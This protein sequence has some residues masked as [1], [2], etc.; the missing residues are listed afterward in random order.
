M[1]HDTTLVLARIV[2]PVFVLA[3]IM[4]ITQPDRM[5]T[6]LGGYL[7]NDSLLL[8]SAFMSLILG[9]CVITFHPR[10]DTVSGIFISL[11]GIVLAARGAVLILAPQLVHEAAMYITTQPHVFPIAGCAAALLGVWL[12]YVGYISGTLRV[13]SGR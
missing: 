7:L 2:G 13:E 6:A 11:I 8:L 9:L 12:T 1:R 10:W 4:L 5:L 3:G